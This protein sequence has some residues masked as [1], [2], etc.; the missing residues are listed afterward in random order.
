MFDFSN[1]QIIL[2]TF[3]YFFLLPQ[4][5]S[6]IPL[7]SPDLSSRSLVIHPFLLTASS[8][9]FSFYLFLPVVFPSFIATRC[10][11]KG[12]F[13]TFLTIFLQS[14]F[15]FQSFFNCLWRPYFW[16]WVSKILGFNHPRKSFVSLD[17]VIFTKWRSIPT[18]F[19]FLYHKKTFPNLV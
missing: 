10:Y 12:Q 18:F 17:S 7:L 16:L 13:C 11:C 1:S 15:Y 4:P 6:T 3:A 14:F 5:F 2:D 19:F 8:G 9:S